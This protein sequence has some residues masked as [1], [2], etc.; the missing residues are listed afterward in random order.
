MIHRWHTPKQYCVHVKVCSFWDGSWVLRYLRPAYAMCLNMCRYYA[1]AEI[2]KRL[3]RSV[4]LRPVAFQKPKPNSTSMGVLY[5]KKRKHTYVWIPIPL[6]CYVT[7]LGITLYHHSFSFMFF[8]DG[9]K[10]PGG[11]RRHHWSAVIPVRESWNL[12]KR[13]YPATEGFP[14]HKKNEGMPS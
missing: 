10:W 1:Q 6:P 13:R 3:F 7:L 2:L 9:K 12:H 8:D 5:V 11:L 14:Y 4:L